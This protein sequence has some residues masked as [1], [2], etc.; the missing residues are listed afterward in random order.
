VAVADYLGPTAVAAT[1]S[2]GTAYLVARATARSTVEAAQIG[3]GVERDKLAHDRAQYR[4]IRRDLALEN[5]LEL[6]DKMG[7]VANDEVRY[8]VRISSAREAHRLL[9]GVVMI[10]ADDVSP[11]PKIA[12]LLAALDEGSL[13][14]AV[15]LWPHVRMTILSAKRQ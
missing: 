10:L 14:R 1:I 5:V 4:D 9:L 13:E 8:D 7:R 2:G 3:A 12:E 11:D 15:G 6:S